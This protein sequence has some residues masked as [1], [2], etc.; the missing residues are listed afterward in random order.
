[1]VTAAKNEKIGQLIFASIYPLYLNRLIKNR[2]TEEELRTVIQ[3]LRVLIMQHYQNLSTKK[4]PLKPEKATIHPN[5][6][7]PKE[8][9]VG[10][11]L[12]K[13]LMNLLYTAS[14]EP[15]KTH[16]WTGQR[17]KNGKDS[18]QVKKGM[19]FNYF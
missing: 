4:S 2:R 8:W 10:I 1:M 15:W 5:A 16:R 12:K 3:W 19:K 11:A 9:F 6:T 17:P 14:V 18:P 13:S 7:W